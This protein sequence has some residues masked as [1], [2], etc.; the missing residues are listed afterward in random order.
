MKAYRSAAVL[1]AAALVL[2]CASCGDKKNKD[3]SK[4]AE[5][6]KIMTSSAAEESSKS[7]NDES[8]TDGE[9]NAEPALTAVDGQF[10]MQAY[11][12]FQSSQY[13]LR[14]TY[15]DP[16]GIETDIYRVVDGDDYYEVQ[17]GDIGTNGCISVNGEAYDF[18]SVCGI[19]RKRTQGKPETLIETVV[20]QRLP[21]TDTNIDPNEAAVY[22]AEEYTYTGGTYIT[23][24]DFYFDKQTGL[25]VKYTT[26]YMVEEEN[27]DEGMTETR[28]VRD[29]MYGAG[30]ELTASDGET[31]ELDR[32]VFDTAFIKDLVDFDSMTAEQKLGYCQAIFV[33]A[34]VTAD[35]LAEAGFGD[36]KL[37]NISYEDFTSLV[38]TY[39]YDA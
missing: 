35:E 7:S 5:N 24:M 26:R 20:E 19:F 1:T 6:N 27:G 29:I 21:A 2:C 33:T 10:I 22:E 12:M 4:S 32:T 18:D 3:S 25:P 8:A 23:V 34:N 17:T 13:S 28:L 14:L 9:D 38:Y 36:D 31:H 16:D 30:G 11:D 39:G 15:T 37:R